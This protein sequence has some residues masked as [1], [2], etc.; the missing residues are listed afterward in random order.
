MNQEEWELDEIRKGIADANAGL[1]TP[2]AE[3]VASWEAKFATVSTDFL[4]E[5]LKEKYGDYYRTPGY[6]LKAY[7]NRADLTQVQL[8][9]KTKVKQHHISEMEHNK[10]PIGKKLAKT[11]ADVLRC[12]YRELL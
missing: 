9:K 10:R 11:I 8:A 7:R 4:Q 12:D 3:V 5:Q 6:L 2:H 1:L